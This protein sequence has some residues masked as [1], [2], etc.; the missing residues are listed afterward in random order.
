MDLWL[1]SKPGWTLCWPT[2]L[3]SPMAMEKPLPGPKTIWV[4]VYLHQG[5]GQDWVYMTGLPPTSKPRMTRLTGKD[6]D[7]RKIPGHVYTGSVDVAGGPGPVG[8]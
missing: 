6:D 1:P 2:Y 7:G 8:I 4:T 5:L 3:T